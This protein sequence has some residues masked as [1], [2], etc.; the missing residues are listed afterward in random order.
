MDKDEMPRIIS[1]GRRRGESRWQ[2]YWRKR[3]MNS[4]RNSSDHAVFM[5]L[6]LVAVFLLIVTVA[7]LGSRGAKFDGGPP[8]GLELNYK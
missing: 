1:P 3:R 2:K 7:I 6:A 5:A 8:G 4:L